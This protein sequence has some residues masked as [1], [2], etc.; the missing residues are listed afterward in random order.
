MRS[1]VLPDD[2]F[3]AA[4]FPGLVGG[5]AALD[6]PGFLQFH[7]GGPD[8]VFTLQADSGEASQGIIPIF[9]ETEHL[10]QQAL[11]LEGEGLVPQVIVAHDG[12]ILG[13]FHTKNCH[14]ISLQLHKN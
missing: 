7:H 9:R 14:N 11:C 3:V 8:G 4:E 12:V 5:L 10:G 2:V 6:I 1:G 13:A